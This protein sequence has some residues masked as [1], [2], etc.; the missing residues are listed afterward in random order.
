LPKARVPPLPLARGGRENLIFLP[1]PYLKVGG[2]G[3]SLFEYNNYK[4]QYCLS[5]KEWNFREEAIKYC[6][7][8]CI[9][10]YQILSKF[11]HL[12]FKEFKINLIKY[13]TLSSLAFGI[14]PS[15]LLRGRL[16]QGPYP[17]Y[18]YF[19][20]KIRMAPSEGELIS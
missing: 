3:I 7:I 10:L 20:I 4:D 12:I 13:P 8:D 15:A 11:N 17:F 5:N 9:S 18:S 6:L 2:G 16:A 14:F 19:R 1:P